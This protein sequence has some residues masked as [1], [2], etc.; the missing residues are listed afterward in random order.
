MY[1]RFC[2]W[3]HVFTYL[4]KYR[5]G[6]EVCDYIHRGSP[7]GTVE[8]HARGRSLLSPIAL[9]HKPPLLYRLQRS[10]QIKI[11]WKKLSTTL[12]SARLVQRKCIV[13]YMLCIARCPPIRW[14]QA[15][16]CK[17]IVAVQLMANGH[18]RIF[19]WKQV[20]GTWYSQQQMSKL[21]R[22]WPIF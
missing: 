10:G 16:P 2:R 22:T 21:C 9:F 12:F 5:Y 15:V 20:Q 3:R 13:R 8:L 19:N 7:G 4:V 17:H 1:F 14:S 6:L 18:G 11:W